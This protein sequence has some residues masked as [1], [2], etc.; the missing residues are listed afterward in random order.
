[1]KN[2]FKVMPLLVL[3]FHYGDKVKFVDPFYGECHGVVVQVY[4]DG[5]NPLYG[6]THNFCKSRSGE[7]LVGSYLKLYEDQLAWEGTWS[8]H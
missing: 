8:I 3:M 1:M 5:L 2:V 6:V 7:S 4:Q